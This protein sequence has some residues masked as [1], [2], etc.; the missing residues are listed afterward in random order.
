MWHGEILN[1]LNE[2]NNEEILIRLNRTLLNTIR[3]RKKTSRKRIDMENNGNGSFLGHTEWEKRL[4]L[5]FY[6]INLLCTDKYYVK[7]I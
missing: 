2:L 1:E 5:V 3:K 7:Y 6:Y 4:T